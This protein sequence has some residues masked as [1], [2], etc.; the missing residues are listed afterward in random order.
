M[1]FMI[2]R[3]KSSALFALAY[4]LACGGVKRCLKIG[5]L[6]VMDVA[7][8]FVNLPQKHESKGRNII[9]YNELHVPKRVGTSLEHA[10]TSWD[11]IHV[12]RSGIRIGVRFCSFLLFP[13]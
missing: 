3:C 2:Q 12:C 11:G 10:G 4:A 8:V 9:K 13:S 5:I 6:A 1:Q 7:K